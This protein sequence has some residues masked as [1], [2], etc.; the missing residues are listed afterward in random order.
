MLQEG[1]KSM[2]RLP[3]FVKLICA[4]AMMLGVYSGVAYGGDGT[5]PKIT[6]HPESQRNVVGANVEFNVTATGENLKYQW[7]YKPNIKGGSW[8]N[9]TD[10]GATT[11]KLKLVANDQNKYLY[12]CLISDDTYSGDKAIMSNAATLYV[13]DGQIFEV[14][15]MADIPSDRKSVV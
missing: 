7:Q 10:S 4:T 2:R 5:P 15:Y 11:N 6:T 14:K 3:K 9:S 12:R 13:L 8:T 1:E